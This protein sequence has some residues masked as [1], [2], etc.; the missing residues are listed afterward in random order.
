VGSRKTHGISG[1]GFG[2][3]E[4]DQNR[5]RVQSNIDKDLRK[6]FSPEFLNRI[7]ETIT[8]N[9]LGMEDMS[10]IVEIL[11][12]DV[13][14]RLKNLEI[15][16]EFTKPCK[17]FLCEVGFDP[18]MGAR[19]LRRAIQRHVEDPLSEKLLRGEVTSKSRLVIGV[20]GDKLSFKTEPMEEV[21]A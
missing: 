13:S 19:P 4:K 8:F 5:Q 2:S 10:Q 9:S 14:D 11:L 17:E 6:T 7:D 12:N 21:K 3:E 20:R 18:K 16:F 15:T 1:V